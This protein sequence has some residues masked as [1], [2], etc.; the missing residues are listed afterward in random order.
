[1]GV[2]TRPRLFGR[3]VVASFEFMRSSGRAGAI[4]A[5]WMLRPGWLAIVASVS[6]DF[7]WRWY[8]CVQ[9][10]F[11]TTP[12]LLHLHIRIFCFGSFYHT[13]NRLMIRALTHSQGEWYLWGLE[14]H[15]SWIY[16]SVVLVLEDGLG[17]VPAWLGLNFALF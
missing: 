17:G 16:S 9:A 4:A 15:A 6:F 14:V 10:D 8:R 2:G 7:D 1:M 11:Q 12:H 5:G 3:H 13:Q